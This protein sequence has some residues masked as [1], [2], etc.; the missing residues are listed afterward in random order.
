MS[1]IHTLV[2][3]V[4]TL[5]GKFGYFSCASLRRY[6]DAC[7]APHGIRFAWL[8]MPLPF[9][10]G[11]IEVEAVLKDSTRPSEVN[12]VLAAGR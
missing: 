12:D 9:S 6:S 3:A 8:R 1:G 7:A 5:V 2:W 11:M 10:M 4:V